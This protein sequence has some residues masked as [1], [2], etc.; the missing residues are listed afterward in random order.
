L[1]DAQDKRRFGSR[2]FGFE[3]PRE[4]LLHRTCF[5][6]KLPRSKKQTCVCSLYKPRGEKMSLFL[7]IG[8]GAAGLA[9]GGRLAIQLYRNYKS[10]VPSVAA[11]VLPKTGSM[12]KYFPGGFEPK[13]T[14]AEAALVLSVRQSASKERIKEA[15]R[16]IMLANHPDSGGSDYL[17]SKINESKDLLLSDEI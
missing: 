15:H 14:R 13:M 5:G 11:G 8:I 1:S 10:R 7:A 12:K 6:K 17:A 9:L 2:H 4:V 16:R 3:S